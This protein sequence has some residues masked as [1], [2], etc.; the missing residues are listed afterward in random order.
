M[1]RHQQ[2]ISGE[3]RLALKQRALLGFFNISRKQRHC[4][5]RR[6]DAQHAA[7]RIGVARALAAGYVSGQR[8][9]HSKID[10]VPLPLL[11]GDAR[12]HRAQGLQM[13]FV[14]NR[15]D[16]LRLRLLRRPWR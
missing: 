5:L 16:E 3:G 7:V 6:A 11:A 8:V 1:V 10:A 2:H 15:A 4:A 13:V 9:Q 14:F 12:L